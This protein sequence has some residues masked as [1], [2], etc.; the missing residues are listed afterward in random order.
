MFK[1]LS[2]LLA[3]ILM[4]ACQPTTSNS[5]PIIKTTPAQTETPMTQPDTVPS[6]DQTT[7]RPPDQ[8]T[9]RPP[10][11]T[12]TRPSDQTTTIEFNRSGGFA[13]FDD[14]YIIYTD[15][16]I[17]YKGRQ[18]VEGIGPISPEQVAE[19][20]QT[21]D[22]INFYSLNA[23]YMP[24]DTCCDFFTFVL[25]VHDG[26]KSHTVTTMDKPG[27]APEALL[28]LL[29]RINQLTSSASAPTQ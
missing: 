13:G 20:W 9:T 5:T 14:S 24:K 7:K 25:T 16:R 2:L 3:L 17:S 10:D 4:V 8:T 26:S 19:L 18:N 6:P 12:T 15:G 11:Q 23:S 1:K 29:I 28:K 21:I 27:A 22:D